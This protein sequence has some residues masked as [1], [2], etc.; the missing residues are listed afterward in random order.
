VLLAM[1][2]SLNITP[3]PLLFTNNPD[4]VWGLIAALFI[5]NFMLLALNLPMVGLFARVLRIPSYYLMP[6]VAMIS[7]IGIYALTNSTFDLMLMICFGVLGWV[8]RKLN[9]PMVP[10]ILGILLGE[11]MEKNLRRA[12][13][14]SDGDLSILY[15]SPLA[16]IFLGMAVAGFVLPI[17][18][19]KFVTPKRVVE[20][21]H[22]DGTSD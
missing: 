12:L 10:V 16:V 6:A 3:G 13:T 8:F 1:L 22:N 9:I 15:G 18:F 21:V 17:F 2:M 4:V 20:Q 5:A 7:F 14:I 19:A 11:L